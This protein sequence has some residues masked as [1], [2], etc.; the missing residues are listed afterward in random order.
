MNRFGL[1]VLA[2]GSLSIPLTAAD[3]PVKMDKGK[4]EKEFQDEFKDMLVDFAKRM[5][6]GRA[7]GKTFVIS[8]PA[9]DVF[10]IGNTTDNQDDP[11]F[12][13]RKYS[14]QGG[15]MLWEQ[16]SPGA[17]KLK[18]RPLQAIATR[19]AVFWRLQ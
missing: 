12:V 3:D 16:T 15:R 13:V 10:A 2:L 17:G 9:G 7:D 8:D 5:I 14:E 11:N 18:W 19:D 1:M 4:K 6:D